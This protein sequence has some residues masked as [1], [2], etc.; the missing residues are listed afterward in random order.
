MTLNRKLSS[1]VLIGALA[2]STAACTK[3]TTVGDPKQSY[4]PPKESKSPTVKPT[5]Q[6]TTEPTVKPTK[7]QTT[8]GVEAKDRKVAAVQ[9]FQYDPLDMQARVGDTIIFE[10]KA[11]EDHS[12]TIDG[13]IDSGPISPGES[14]EVVVKLAKGTYDYHCTLVPYMV[15][16]KLNVY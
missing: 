10:N 9:G 5:K 14:Y 4:T 2:F 1:L 11:S 7:E 12:F 15:G 3:G 13:E 16:G 6:E 8:P